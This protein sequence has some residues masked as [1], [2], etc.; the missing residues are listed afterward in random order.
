MLA[1]MN[2][3]DVYVSTTG[4]LLHVIYIRLCRGNSQHSMSVHPDFNNIS[5]DNYKQEILPTF[6]LEL[7]VYVTHLLN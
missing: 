2:V 4:Y 3:S 5:I 7:H 6:I 1:E